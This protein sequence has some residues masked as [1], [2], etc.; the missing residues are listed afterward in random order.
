MYNKRVSLQQKIEYLAEKW[1][2]YTIVRWISYR[3]KSKWNIKQYIINRTMPM[4]PNEEWINNILY[5]SVSLPTA[6]GKLYNDVL[7]DNQ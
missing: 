2:S 6:I 7:S 1:I 5:T 3:D 4:N